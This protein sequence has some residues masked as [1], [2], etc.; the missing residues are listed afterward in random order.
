VLLSFFLNRESLQ[1]VKAALQGP[2][3]HS[4]AGN[5]GMERVAAMGS[6]NC[7]C[8]SSRSSLLV[9]HGRFEWRPIVVA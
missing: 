7:Y 6:T 3:M 9:V 2:F 1:E 8:F 4:T 5:W